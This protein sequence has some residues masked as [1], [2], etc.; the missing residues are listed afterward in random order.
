MACL[1]AF[2]SRHVGLP[3][4]VGDY[5]YTTTITNITVRG[6]GA[7]QLWCFT[8]TQFSGDGSQG[9]N[10]TSLVGWQATT[11]ANAPQTSATFVNSLAVKDLQDLV[12]CEL[13][14]SSMSIR[15]TCPTPVQTAQ[16]QFF[17]GRWNIACDPREYASYQAIFDG[18]MSYGCP[19]PLTAARLAFKGVECSAMPRNMTDYSQFLHATAYDAVTPLVTIAPYP[20][21]E[22][23]GTWSGFSPIFLAVSDNMPATTNLNVQIAV[24][25]RYRFPVNNPASTTHM[26]QAMST[27]S[28]LNDLMASAS[29]AKHGVVAIAEAGD[30]FFNDAV[31]AL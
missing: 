1:N 29:A 3:R 11:L 4:A 13:V 12:G 31:G 25:W 23:V 20:F 18:F 8:P 10:M 16:G 19:R 27:D 9:M 7:D 17:L 15:I 22:Q 26:Y 14:P 24:K 30:A 6:T 28:G 21:T 2:G 5:I